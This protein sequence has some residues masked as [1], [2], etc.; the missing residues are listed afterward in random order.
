VHLGEERLQ[1]ENEG[2]GGASGPPLQPSLLDLRTIVAGLP[3]F[4]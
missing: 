2:F 3:A 4:D 1:V